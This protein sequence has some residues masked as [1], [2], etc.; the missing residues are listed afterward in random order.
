MNY[1]ATDKMQIADMWICIWR[2]GYRCN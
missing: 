1:K 2:N